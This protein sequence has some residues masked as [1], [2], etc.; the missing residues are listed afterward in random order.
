MEL[1]AK[2]RLQSSQIQAATTREA[3]KYIKSVFDSNG[4]KGVKVKDISNNDKSS[5]MIEITAT[6]PLDSD[7][8]L[9]LSINVGP[10]GKANVEIDVGV[11]DGASILVNS[12]MKLKSLKGADIHKFEQWNDTMRG[13]T[14]PS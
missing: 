9:L 10:K 8:S 1:Q 13:S 11:T 12:W 3:V 2:E 7:Y 6:D 5:P 4:V 14:A